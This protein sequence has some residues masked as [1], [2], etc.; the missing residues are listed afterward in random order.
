MNKSPHEG[1]STQVSSGDG[2][3]I[4][5]KFGIIGMEHTLLAKGSLKEAPF[6]PTLPKSAVIIAGCL[7]CRRYRVAISRKA[8]NLS[9][10]KDTGGLKKI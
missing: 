2:E 10:P 6:H 1:G 3:E 7:Y 9:E 8:R 4:L 5:I